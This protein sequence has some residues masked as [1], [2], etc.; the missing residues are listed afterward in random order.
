[1]ATFLHDIPTN[2]TIGQSIV[3]QVA[4]G[5]ITGAGVD[6]LATDGPAFV[7]V[8]FGTIGD[9]STVELT[10]QESADQ[11][12][13]NTLTTDLTETDTDNSLQVAKVRRTLRF[14]R[15]NAALSGEEPSAALS[16]TIAAQKKLI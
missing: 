14:L 6:L 9:G 11:T 12:A 3:P 13:W 1:M 10:V 7:L 15:V 2:A 8:S 16:V 5:N 4:T